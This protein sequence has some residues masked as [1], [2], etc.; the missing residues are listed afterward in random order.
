M[1][2]PTLT[3]LRTEAD[4]LLKLTAPSPTFQILAN[5]LGQANNGTQPDPDASTDSLLDGIRTWKGQAASDVEAIF[6]NQFMRFLKNNTALEAQSAPV[7]QV[8]SS[9]TPYGF[10]VSVPGA[11]FGDYVLVAP[12]NPLSIVGGA[13]RADALVGAAG[14]VSVILYCLDGVFSTNFSSVTFN[15]KVI[16]KGV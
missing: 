5:A 13:W 8:V 7:T 10:G 3:T 1:S 2:T 15:V 11:A 9:G 16:K 6:A 12:N 14:Q 4:Q